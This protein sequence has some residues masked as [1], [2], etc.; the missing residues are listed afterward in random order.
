MAST[1]AMCIESDFINDDEMNDTDIPDNMMT[2]QTD[3]KTLGTLF[4]ENDGKIPLLFDSHSVRKDNKLKYRIPFRQRY[5]ISK[6]KE[7]EKQLLVDSVFK[8]FTLEGITLSAQYDPDI[9]MHY[10]DVENGA[11]RMSVLQSYAKDGFKYKGKLYSEL[12]RRYQNRFDRYLLPMTIITTM[13]TA[14]VDTIDKLFYRLNL[15]KPLTDADRYWSMNSA[16]PLVSC[17]IKLMKEA[18]WDNKL[19]KTDKFGDKNRACLPNVCSLVATL[20]FGKEYTRTSSKILEPI[21]RVHLDYAEVK[22]KVETF[23]NYYKQIIEGA[24][25]ETMLV[26]HQMDW[27][28]TSKQMGLI[29]HDYL[30]D[31][32]I[33]SLNAKKTMWINTMKTARKAQNFWFGK[34]TIWNGLPKGAKQNMCKFSIKQRLN[35]VKNFADITKCDE[36]CAHEHI[37]CE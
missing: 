32:S 29:L 24:E 18:F 5:G 4:E 25:N 14:P 15:G 20:Q 10:F 35:R 8:G 19:M 6:W 9:N 12:E 7:A 3:S 27:E 1:S 13:P 37:E 30:D 33:E 22:N 11:S 34:Q 17:V 2:I 23:L 16:S 26:S 21:L 36:L 28:K 31:V